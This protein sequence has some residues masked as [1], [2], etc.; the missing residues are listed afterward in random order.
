MFE[1]SPG[2]CIVG[3]DF[4]QQEPRLLTHMTRDEK[5]IETYQ[6]KRDL[7]ATIASSVYHK[8]YWE[9]MEHWEDKT[10]NPEGKAIRSKAK[11]IVL[12]IMYG[13]GA[14]L[15]SSILGTD[16]DE[17]KNILEEF[18]KMFPKVKE[19]TAQNEQTAKELGYVEDYLGRRR[20]LPDAKLS[21][22]EVRAKKSIITDCDLFVE[23]LSGDS[24]IEI[25]DD[26][27][28]REWTEKWKDCENSKKFNAK[29]DFKKLAK[30]CGIA[31][32]D[33]GAFI[34]KTLTQ[35]TNARI[36]GSAA[37]LTKKAMVNIFNDEEMNRL[38]FRILIPVHDE[39]LGECP[40]EN[41]EAVEKRLVELMIGAGKPECSVPMKCD[42]YVVKHWHADEVFNSI[43]DTH[44]KNV[45]SGKSDEESFLLIKKEHSE[46]KDETIRSMCDGTFDVLSEDI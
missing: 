5:L 23:C 40:I 27:A 33:N 24:T 12:G 11:S 41:A 39:L 17:C 26:D 34:S 2:Y 29:R 3:G 15:L 6:N 1:A 9:C 44:V 22:I 7:Y 21:E 30:E 38:G 43:H 18:Y 32:Y 4:S 42:T 25:P 35:C 37:T 10:P 19:F 20:H 28:I 8:D 46:L 36:Q 45:K 14:K 16:I 13:M 31:L